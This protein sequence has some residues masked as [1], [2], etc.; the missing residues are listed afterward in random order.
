MTEGGFPCHLFTEEEHYEEGPL[1]DRK[2]ILPDLYRDEQ[3]AEF[4][5]DVI[6]LAN[7]ARMLGRPGY[8]LYGIDDFGNLCGLGNSIKPFR[9]FRGMTDTESIRHRLNEIIPRYIKE[10]VLWEFDMLQIGDKDVAYLKVEPATPSEPYT[11]KE[12][13]SSGN[14]VLLRVGECWIRFGESKQ[15]I[16]R[17]EIAPTDAPYR[18]AYSQ[19]PYV[20][21]S[22]WQAYLNGL[23]RDRG[24]DLNAASSILGYQELKVDQ[25]EHLESTVDRFLASDEQL[26]V[27][28]GTAGSGKSVFLRR[29]ARRL[30]DDGLVSIEGRIRREEYLP[31]SGWIP[32]YFPLGN[33][34]VDREFRL[35]DR[36][37][38]VINRTSGGK[39]WSKQRPDGPEELLLN[40]KLRWLV[41]LDGL[42]EIKKEEERKR[43]L[44]ELRLFRDKFPM[45]K[46]I[47][48]TRP[49]LQVGPL[50][51]MGSIVTIAPL[52]LEQ[53][54]A[55]IG[56]FLTSD[57]EQE[58]LGLLESEPDLKR[59]L[60][61]PMYLEAA[62][63][64]LADSYP[65]SL[66]VFPPLEKEDGLSEQMS[67]MSQLSLV[68][69]EVYAGGKKAKPRAVSE[70]EIIL[71][72]PETEQPLERDEE[73]GEN[74]RIEQ[75]ETVIIPLYLGWLLDEMYRYVWQRE[76]MKGSS[77]RV[78]T[79][80]WT[81]L[82]K[83]ALSLDGQRDCAE[84][85]EVRRWLGSTA[86]I[87][88]VLGLGILVRAKYLGPLRF[89]TGLTKAFFAA[90]RLQDLLE[91]SCVKQARCAIDKLTIEFRGKVKD[92]LQPMSLKARSLFEGGE[93]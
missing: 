19:V 51:E 67:Q 71:Q 7:T 62:M 85:D 22:V 54:L 57:R 87:E 13:L 15:K 79:E 93:I 11:V 34:T 4:V 20:L 56:N 81:N 37:L 21:P 91:I 52:S 78:K 47:V 80:W 84:D 55:Y 77:C 14:R 58:V 25:G 6:A 26:L 39:F 45:V 63:H 89:T 83:L 59:L 31:P 50:Q 66:V 8:L 1:R 23:L 48:A 17:R 49:D 74:E 12:E 40:P 76:E 86:A 30:A 92:L 27:V 10:V 29:L 46:L 65:P 18:Y 88:W 72:E 41:L 16:E 24:L 69:R 33:L 9:R 61:I 70:N 32:I 64:Q 38:D 90:S 5:R 3:K 82:G 68:D 42:D 44:S 36:L 43:F 2:A 75:E 35:H 60:S 53:I 73:N 28:S